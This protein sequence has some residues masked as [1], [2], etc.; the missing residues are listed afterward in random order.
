MSN[1]PKQAIL[2]SSQAIIFGS[3]G[4][5]KTTE[6]IDLVSNLESEGLGSQEILVLTPSR[7]AAN[8]LR[9][10]IALNSNLAASE[11]RA[12]S[13]SSFAF[14]VARLQTPEIKLL[15]GAGQQAQ[16]AGLILDAV[17]QGEH[18]RWGVDRTTALL[19]GFGQEVR[20]LLSV[21]IENRLSIADL[22][23]M[24]ESFESKGLRVAIDLLPRYMQR[25]EELNALDP[26][27]LLVVATQHL[28][29]YPKPKYVLIDDAQDLSEAGLKLALALSASSK[30]ILFGD[31]D[32][33]VAGFRS[34]GESF[35][36]K[37]PD[38]GKYFLDSNYQNDSRAGLMP[39]VVNRI[40][41]G[42]AASHRPKS[43]QVDT[44]TA[45]IF[46]N[47]SDETDWLAAQLRRAKLLDGFAW[48][49]MAVI[50]RTRVQLDQLAQ[51][52]TA[53]N[54]PVR[55]L[56]VQKPLRQQPAALG[57][58]EFG[59]LVFGLGKIDKEQFLSSPLVGF[60]S[61]G[62]R[63]LMRELRQGKDSPSTRSEISS[64]LFEDL[65]ES[66]SFEIKRLNEIT[67]LRLRLRAKGSMSAYEFVSAAI[68]LFPLGRLEALSRGRG[69][70]ALAANR[71]LDALLELVAAAQ[72]FDARGWGSA[73]EF[74]HQQ[75]ELA[76]PEDSL[77]PIG[78][79][80]AVTLAT[81]AQL[82]GKSF[83]LVAL[84][85]LQEGIW[86]NLRPRNA[87][88]G[89]NALQSYLLGRLESPIA[90]TKS[91][92]HDEVRLFYKAIGA[93]KD[94]LLLSAISAIDE[95]PSQFFTM[96]DIAVERSEFGMDFDLRRQVGK[97]RKRAFSG[98]SSAIAMLATLAL[99]GA[100]GAHPKNW[101]GLLPL[102]SDEPISKGEKTRMSASKLEA[103]EKCPLHWFIETF[104]GETGNF[105]ASLGTLLHAALEA[106]AQGS[107][108]A[109]YVQSNWHTLE[110]ES[111]WYSLAQQRRSAKMVSFLD[112]YLRSSDQLHAAEQ[113]F[114][115]ETE[116]LVVSGKIDRI[117]QSSEGMV[118]VDLKTGKPPTKEEV[119]RNR[120]LAL[121]QLALQSQGQEVAG[122]RII[123]VGGDSLRVIEQAALSPEL[124][125]EIEAL[126]AKAE[127]EAGG[128]EFVAAISSHCA[129]D[130]QC[131]LLIAKSVQNG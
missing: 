101:Q 59:T 131:Q 10:Q 7:M 120:Q 75:L 124:R 43:M 5:G 32:A 96:F 76:I 71:E 57:V 41:A 99:S 89:A 55:I 13:I 79:R 45:K 11:P 63:R 109:E 14:E 1:I 51:D 103:F 49:Q 8:S 73:Q 15:S 12:R 53:R 35:A 112:E 104:S 54:V 97:L 114:A 64:A 116:Q 37:F 130:A 95:T 122:A 20:D 115:F 77:A 125:T 40:P 52:L 65:V 6:L 84:P 86:P 9:D 3:P 25:L 50:A 2:E 17:E 4:S 27:E 29:S 62:I 123:A 108:V 18:L 58:L 72:R 91:E 80:P 121:Y 60:D 34:S 26:S 129:D 92:L 107:D 78:L 100:P 38:A 21:V 24:L 83:D 39:R 67:E 98:D 16:I 87:L 82:A 102:S 66:D 90:Q 111:Q 19:S 88:L 22:K 127:N 23:V 47:Q 119:A 56:G 113:G 93:A 48:E 94:R 69:N 31:P 81:S 28:A 105:Q 68:K 117:E 44:A 61:L 106:S 126:L 70:I 36:A 118:V 33:A 42:L 30:L 128:S 46:D 74:V 110:F 85:R